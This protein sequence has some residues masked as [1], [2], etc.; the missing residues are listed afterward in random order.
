MKDQGAEKADRERSKSR[1]EAC[2][3]LFAQ[4]RFDP[5][6]EKK[7]FRLLAEMD[8]D[9]CMESLSRLISRLVFSSP[10]LHP[11]AV[12]L[13]L[14]DLLQKINRRLHRSQTDEAAYQ[15]NRLALLSLYS[16]LSTA[17]ESR[18]AFLPALS[19]L[20]SPLQ[21]DKGSSHPLVRSA[22]V[23]IH[24]NY[25][26]RLSLSTISGI[27]HVSANY[28]S[29]LFRKETGKTITRYIQQIR[30]EHALVLLAE[31]RRSISEIAYTVGYQNYRDFYRNF[32]KYEK[33]SPRQVQRRLSINH[34]PSDRC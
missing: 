19:A 10:N 27:L 14:H 17:E 32:V 16:G 21:T 6:L 20:L 11:G 4:I 1:S 33:E 23:Y 7:A 12:R 24:E 26:Q 22:M 28:L 2:G 25:H 8:L 9:G 31:G 15:E 34:P 5:A 13:L 18:N 3:S 29:R 30:L